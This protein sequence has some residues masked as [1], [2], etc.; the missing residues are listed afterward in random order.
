MKQLRFLV[1]S[2]CLILSGC[3]FK[4]IDKRVFISA[5]GID[6]SE[7][8]EGYKVT[9]KIALPIGSV[10]DAS[11]AK[12]AYFSKEGDT[13]GESLRILETHTDKVLEF[14]HLKAIV[15]H[16][17]LLANGVEEY[18]DYFTRR[19]D[20]QLIAYIVAARPTAEDVLKTE[21]STESAST[22]SIFNFFDHTGTESPFITTTFLFQFRREYYGKGID[23]FVPIMEANED[24]TELRVNKAIVTGKNDKFLALTSVQTKYYNSVFKE[25]SGFD[26]KVKSDDLVLMLNIDNI[27]TSY[28]IITE[29]N[30]P[31][32]IKLD[33]KMI[34]IIGQSNKI[35]SINKLDEYNKLSSK[36][37]EKK[38]L[39]FL[40]MLQEEELDPGFGLRY[41]ATRLNEEGLFDKWKEAYPTLPIDVT[42][43]V[44]LKST[45]AIE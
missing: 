15:I 40:K 25:M 27:R 9:V 43:D 5:I 26:Y 39:D 10:K 35:L 16:E 38:L 2:L 3:G 41:R 21:P 13:I 42:V 17:E 1:I 23:T 22:V 6:P 34:G 33:V 11:G 29:N 24:K 28:K 32:S 19:G 31:V 14:G 7:S 4:D 37:I 45:G 12:Y 18:M 44:Q 30:Q 8:G 36:A 20:I